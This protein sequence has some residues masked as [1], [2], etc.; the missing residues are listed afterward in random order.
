[1]G[2]RKHTEN[3]KNR[4]LSERIPQKLA[5]SAGIPP[6]AAGLFLKTDLT[7]EFRYGDVWLLVH[8]NTLYKYCEGHSIET[9]PLRSGDELAV[10]NRGDHAR[11]FSAKRRQASYCMPRQQCNEQG[12]R[13]FT[14][15]VTKLLH[16]EENSAEMPEL[17]REERCPNCGR[18]YRDD[19]RLC[20][21]CVNKARVFRRLLAYAGHYKSYIIFILTFIH[22]LP[23][24]LKS[25]R[26]IFREPYFSTKC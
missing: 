25:W 21:H 10:G 1:M 7:D 16:G 5:E 24:D 15:A 3:R 13:K 14:A 23:P 12:L 2:N 4:D 18:P 20:P 11:N 26:R 6:E 8:N 17:E 19:T 9:Y 22:S